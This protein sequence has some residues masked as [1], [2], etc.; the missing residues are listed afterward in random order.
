MRLIRF[1]FV[2]ASASL[3]LLPVVS[4]RK[5]SPLFDDNI[6]YST[7]DQLEEDIKQA[8][9]KNSDRLK[10]AQSLFEKAGAKPED[11][12]IAKI[13][14]I[15][16]LVI[17]KSGKPDE[18]VII[19]AHYDKVEYGCGAIDNWTG[20]VAIA[21]LYKALKDYPTTK[22]LLFV[23]FDQEEK[24]LLGSHAMVDAIPKDQRIHYCAMI[25]IDSLGMTYPH[26]PTNMSSKK[27]MDTAAATAKEMG[28]QFTESPIHDADAD[29]S[30]FVDKK[31]PAITFDG[32][33][34][35]WPNVLHSVRDQVAKVNPQS[36]YIG[37]RLALALA[38]KVDSASC[39]SFR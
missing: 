26:A 6:T 27:I 38:Q 10:V 21:H 13:G 14:G 22:T 16:N 2:V 23:G 11:I 9:C 5:V 31:I 37:Y 8:P 1:I 19:G 29:S 39:E 35:D 34:S 36:V 24:G 15:K 3:F 20:I 7:P 4:A 32:L 28:I 17:K 25:N 33:T 18:I 12:S 30:S